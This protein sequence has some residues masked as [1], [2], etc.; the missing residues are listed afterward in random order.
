[1]SASPLRVAVLSPQAVVREGLAAILARNDE[2][3][4]VGL[5]PTEASPD[6][7]LYDSMCMLV[8]DAT[9]L[10]SLVSSTPTTVL[11][12][13]R[14]LRPGLAAR[15]LAAG[16]DGLVSVGAG[17]EEIFEAINAAISSRR[18]REA[19][20]RHGSGD[21][22]D[23]TQREAQVLAMLSRGWSNAEISAGLQMSRN[24]VKTH[25]RL[26]YRKIGVKDRAEA[27][28]WTRTH[29]PSSAAAT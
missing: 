1:M 3:E 14:D 17:P 16:A 7:V 28:A 20:Q 11:V 25:I 2:V 27:T 8:G 18:L 12:V 13:S 9:E 6:V 19:G 23:L 21:P 4:L 26:A 10:D 5:D 22:G 15:A 29:Q 24:T